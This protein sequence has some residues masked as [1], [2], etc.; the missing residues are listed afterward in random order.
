MNQILM[1]LQKFVWR[2]LNAKNETTM[3]AKHQGRPNRL[4]A[5]PMLRPMRE[6]VDL[7]AKQRS[8]VEVTSWNSPTSLG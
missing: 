1:V 2:E 8:L 4:L 3:A 5:L 7:F 6:I